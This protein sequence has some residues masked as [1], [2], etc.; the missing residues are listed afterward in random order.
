VDL[1][2]ALEFDEAATKRIIQVV[3]PGMEIFKVSPKT[4]KGMTEY[5][6]FLETRRIRLRAAAGVLK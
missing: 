4:G 3:W 5:P 1:A 2:A 6:E